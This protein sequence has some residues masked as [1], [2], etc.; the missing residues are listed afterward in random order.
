MRFIT[1]NLL[2]RFWKKGITPIKKLLGDKDI[3]KIGDGTVTGAISE[4]NPCLVNTYEHQM[5]L[6][7]I[8]VY[9]CTKS[10]RGGL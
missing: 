3:S 8:C 9:F 7:L 2:N 4:L 6:V 10:K 1:L 5:Y